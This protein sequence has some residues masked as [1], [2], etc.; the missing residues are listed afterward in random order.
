MSD[1]ET[2]DSRAD[3]EFGGDKLEGDSSGDEDD[4]HM[5]LPRPALLRVALES[6]G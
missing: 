4:V 1:T 3:S 5:P 2:A 6:L